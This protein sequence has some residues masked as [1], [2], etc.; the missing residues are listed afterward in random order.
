MNP[1]TVAVTRRRGIT[2]P[3]VLV[4][5][6][7]ASHAPKAGA[8]LAVDE[9]ELRLALRRGMPT[10]SESFHAANPSEK[11]A[12]VTISVQDWDRS[13]AGENRYYPLGTLPTSCASHIKVF[14]SVLQLDPRSV[15]TVRV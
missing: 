5:L 3:A 9:L 15:Q 4:L 13:E 12:Q 2:F 10:A 6:V 8:Q 11:R 7:V 14:P 1:Q